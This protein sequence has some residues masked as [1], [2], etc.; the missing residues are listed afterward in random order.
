MPPTEFWLSLKYTI[1]SSCYT[2]TPASLS[3]PNFHCQVFRVFPWEIFATIFMEKCIQLCLNGK[4]NHFWQILTLF[5]HGAGTI[6]FENSH[7]IEK[8]NNPDYEIDGWD[9]VVIGSFGPN[10]E[11]HNVYDVDNVIV[12]LGGPYHES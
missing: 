12:I 10:G 6:K 9:Y 7:H 3:G 8:I 5:V 2:T 11:G 1:I 4:P